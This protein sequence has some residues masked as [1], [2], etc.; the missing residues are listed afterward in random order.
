MITPTSSVLQGFT[1][2]SLCVCARHRP[3]LLNSSL[4]VHYWWLGD[5]GSTCS[6]GDTA[7]VD[8][9]PGSG[10][11]AGGG[12]GSTLQCSCLENPVDRGAWQAAVHGVATSQT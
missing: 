4:F 2:V 9:I 1:G 5:K 7:G 12:N 10:R 11:S 3:V 8:L 6:A